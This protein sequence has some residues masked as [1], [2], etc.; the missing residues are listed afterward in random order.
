MRA[1][2]DLYA[3][4]QLGKTGLVLRALYRHGRWPCIWC[5]RGQSIE[6]RWGFGNL[7]IWKSCQN[8]CVD[9][10]VVHS[11][12]GGFSMCFSCLQDSKEV[13]ITS[14]QSLQVSTILAD[15]NQ[16]VIFECQIHGCMRSRFPKCGWCDVSRTIQIEKPWGTWISYG[17]PYDFMISHDISWY[18][19]IF[20]DISWYFM[21]LIPLLS[22][23]GLV[24]LPCPQRSIWLMFATRSC[25]SLWQRYRAQGLVISDRVWQGILGPSFSSWSKGLT[26]EQFRTCVCQWHQLISTC[27]DSKNLQSHTFMTS[28]WHPLPGLIRCNYLQLPPWKDSLSAHPEQWQFLGS[29]PRCLQPRRR[30]RLPALRRSGHPKLPGHMTPWWHHGD[31]WWYHVMTPHYMTCNDV[32]SCNDMLCISEIWTP[33]VTVCMCVVFPNNSSTAS[34]KNKRSFES[35]N[36]LQQW[37][38]SAGATLGCKLVMQCSPSWVADPTHIPQS[39][40]NHPTIISQSS[41]IYSRN[42]TINH[43]ISLEIMDI[44]DPYPSD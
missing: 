43:P 27:P 44:Y 22:I 19:M 15:E 3:F 20:H 11:F 9:A 10:W 31:T 35:E 12:A 24:I 14:V 18:F 1:L 34:C 32:Q 40:H 42:G 16:R 6:D 2:S 41:P 33:V 25:I 30:S 29:H 5:T 23:A 4:L 21:N 36:E 39:S 13:Y 38:L 26:F 37:S 17:A 8:R 7:S 28:L